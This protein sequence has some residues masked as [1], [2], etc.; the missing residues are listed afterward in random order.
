MSSFGGEGHLC[1]RNSIMQHLLCAELYDE[2]S[3][4]VTEQA[5]GGRIVGYWGLTGR[6]V[7][8]GVRGFSLG[9]AFTP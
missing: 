2:G 3:A 1:L 5:A 6:V 8:A 7:P 9:P 4:A